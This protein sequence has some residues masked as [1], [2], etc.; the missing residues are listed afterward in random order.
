MDEA[1]N[2]DHEDRPDVGADRGDPLGTGIEQFQRA[3]LDAVRA[4]RA[5]LDVAE[6]VIADPKAVETVLRS[7]TTIARTTTESVAT[8][9]AGAAG[10]RAATTEP[11][12]HDADDAGPDDAGPDDSGFQRIRVD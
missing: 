2:D 12:D 10:N 4:A 7:A 9:V 6:S 1:A 5:M 8:F 11:V 3:A